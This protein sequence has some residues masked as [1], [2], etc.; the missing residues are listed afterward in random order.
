MDTRQLRYYVALIEA[1]T[2]TKAAEQLHISQPSLSAT[3]K[4]LKRVLG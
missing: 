2:Y 3:I 1:G 4:N